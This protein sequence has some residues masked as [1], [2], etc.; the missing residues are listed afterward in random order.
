M[1]HTEVSLK[2]EKLKKYININPF[3]S[4]GLCVALMVS[5]LGSALTKSVQSW[6][7]EWGTQRE[8]WGCSYECSSP[9]GGRGP[10]LPE[11]GVL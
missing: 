5:G 6:G 8:L 11:G 2:K 3:W 10:F 4:G 7:K 1:R 9:K